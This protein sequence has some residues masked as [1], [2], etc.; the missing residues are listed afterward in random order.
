MV[1]QGRL[2]GGSVAL[3]MSTWEGF[4]GRLSSRGESPERRMCGMW[5]WRRRRR[6]GPVSLV[7][8]NQQ[9]S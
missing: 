7:F 8:G 1:Y 9:G 5:E 3:V 6:P 4:L 2:P